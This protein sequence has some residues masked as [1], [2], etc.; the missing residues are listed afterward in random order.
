MNRKMVA[1]VLAFVLAVGVSGCGAEGKQ[2]KEQSSNNSGKKVVR[3]LTPGV[4]AD[5]N[6]ALQ[7]SI[8]IA[9]EEGYL[10]EELKAAGYTAEYTG[11]A[12][13]GVGINEALAAGEGDVAVYG[14]FP[15][16]TYISNNGDASIFAVASS[17]QQLG[18][19]AADGIDDVKSLKGKKIGVMFGTVSYKYLLD[20]LDENGLT[21]DD[22]ELVNAT[23]DLASLYLSGDIDAVS[24]GNEYLYYVKALGGKG[25]VISISGKDAKLA[26]N[27]VIIGKNE[28]LE[29]NPKVAEAFRK[30]LKK[31]QQFAQESPDK[32]YEAFAKQ[33]GV[34]TE[35]IY[36]DNY[37][38]DESFSFW[39]PDVTDEVKQR[40]QTTADFMYDNSYL[41]NKVDIEK[42]V[43]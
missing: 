39:N 7:E 27:F 9:R 43:K 19:L 35:D 1:A 13:A 40:L 14:D 23:T 25:N 42:A 16:I 6:A 36:R 18:I 37:K 30:A 3:I 2:D 24:H 17:R 29:K 20:V 8:F 32:V 28:Y 5:G 31:A 26:S 22:V 11:F 10:D 12:S 33:S 38:F 41:G 15:A 4:D 34:M 21:K